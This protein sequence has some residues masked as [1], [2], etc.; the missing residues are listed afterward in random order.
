MHDVG[1]TPESLSG[2]IEF[3]N[4]SFSFPTRPDEPVFTNFNLTIESGKT[5]AIVGERFE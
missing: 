2:T 3:R 1:A 5:V 4:V